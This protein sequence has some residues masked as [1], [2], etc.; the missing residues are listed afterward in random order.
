MAPVND[1][2]GLNPF[3]WIA[4]LVALLTLL[5]LAD[6]WAGHYRRDFIH[7][8]QYAPFVSGGLLVIAAITTVIAPQNRAIALALGA[9]G[10]LAIV[11]GVIGFC[12]HHYY[13]IV[14]KP[15][16]YKLL[17]N[18]LMYNA[19]PL[20]PLA[21][22]AMGVFALIAE[23]GLAGNG[24]IAGVPIRVALLATIVVCLV[25]AITQAGILHF[26]GAFN[27]PLMYAPLT[28]PVVTALTGVWMMAEPSPSVL[29]VLV[30]LFWLTLL[31][32]FVGLGM[33]LRGLDRQM[34]G[35][36][37]PLFNWLQGPPP[38]APAMFAGLSAIGLI[39]TSL[40]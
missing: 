9:A 40:L 30:F 8:V 21:L 12:F 35:L 23:R 5:I 19:P 36:Y 38:F 18:S 26:R 33:H 13:G 39:T 22:T 2:I 17:L 24:E 32:G 34:A 6:A 11:V 31:T 4:L 15:G 3:Q 16:G 1:F 14:R 37:V 28:I 10:W 25:G 29:I 27:N 7:R 20:A